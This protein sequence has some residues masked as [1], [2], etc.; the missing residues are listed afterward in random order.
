MSQSRQKRSFSKQEIA[1]HRE[2]SV[3]K[4]EMS[5]KIAMLSTKMIDLKADFKRQSSQSRSAKRVIGNFKSF[6]LNLT[7]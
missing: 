5:K 2:W 7:F 6:K 3:F 1:S 4:Y